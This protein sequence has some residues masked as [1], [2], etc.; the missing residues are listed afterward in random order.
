MPTGYLGPRPSLAARQRGVITIVGIK[1]AP[2]PDLNGDVRKRAEAQHKDLRTSLLDQGW[3]KVKIYPVIIGNAG[4]ITSIANDALQA[5]GVD[6][7]ARMTLLKRLAV[8]SLRR[9]AEIWK[10]RISQ[11][12]S[13]GAPP[14]PVP[15]P[16]RPGNP[17]APDPMHPPVQY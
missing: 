6:A 12:A 15:S 9:T 10:P 4:T 7:A 5:L 8:E 17:D 2:D 13:R 14:R 3:G 1:Y 16:T 11:R